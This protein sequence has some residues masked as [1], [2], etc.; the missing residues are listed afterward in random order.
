MEIISCKEA[1]KSGLKYYFTGKPCSN[2]HI[3]PRLTYKWACAEC[4]I[5][6]QKDFL[7]KNP[8]WRTGSNRYRAPKGQ[9][10]VAWA[11]RDLIKRIYIVCKRVTK[12]TNVKH[13]VDHI[14]PIKGKNVCGLHVH[15]N[16]AIVPAKY[17]LTKGNKFVA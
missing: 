7:K 2:G 10:I 1:R 8:D 5:I 3:S 6:Y 11:D 14:I 15:N 9:R 13:N 4:A 12:D 16:L 17:N